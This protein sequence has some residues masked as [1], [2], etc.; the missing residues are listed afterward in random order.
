MIDR[1]ATTPLNFVTQSVHANYMNTQ[2]CMTTGL[3]DS[4]T[5]GL[6][7]EMLLWREL[8]IFHFE[9][10]QICSVLKKDESLTT[11]DWQLLYKRL[12]K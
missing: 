12:V 6:T 10:R 3:T 11:I 2:F 5:L 8:C 1:A 7:Q 9:N 4:R